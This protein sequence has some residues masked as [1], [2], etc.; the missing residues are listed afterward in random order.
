[1]TVRYIFAA[2]AAAG[3]ICIAGCS[4]TVDSGGSVPV[5]NGVMPL[6][7]GNEWTYE[8]SLRDDPADLFAVDTITVRIDR[9]LVR[10]HEIWYIP[11]GYIRQELWINRGDEFWIQ[12]FSGAP[13]KF[14]DHQL[15]YSDTWPGPNG[16]CDVFILYNAEYC[17]ILTKGA[18]LCDY[19]ITCT[20]E[21]G[22]IRSIYRFV[23]RL[24]IAN[25]NIMTSLP[26]GSSYT[27]QM[28]R[29]IDYA[30]PNPPDGSHGEIAFQYYIDRSNIPPPY[31]FKVVLM[32][33][34]PP[35]G[36]MTYLLDADGNPAIP[37]G[38]Y[39][40][41]EVAR[42][43]QTVQDVV[44]HNVPCGTHMLTVNLWRMDGS[45]RLSSVTVRGISVENGQ[46]TDLGLIS[47]SAPPSP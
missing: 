6:S 46:T 13:Y 20:G 37:V 41:L 15:S 1:M 19:V 7:I 34:D 30:L 42:Q 43:Y 25:A 21:P 26:N 10:N 27:S 44:I 39:S 45:E 40:P 33:S 18:F 35:F 22:N 24:G 29:L 47:S 4:N 5:D 14:A 2:F 32:L 23:P 3:L 12:P 38:V 17:D 31:T 8:R 9:C 36:S 11:S 28:L 16:E